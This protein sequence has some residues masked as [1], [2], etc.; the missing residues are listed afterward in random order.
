MNQ[1]WIDP[2]C[3]AGLVLFTLYLLV[4]NRGYYISDTQVPTYDEAWYL[5][6][7]LDLY[8]RLTQG[9]WSQFWEAYRGAFGAKAPLIAV[10]PLPFYLL[11]GAARESAMLVNSLLVALSNLCLFWMVRRWFSP[12]AALAAVVFYQ[13]MPLAYGLSRAFMAEYG[14]AALVLAWMCL[15]AASQR[16]ERTGVNLALGV[17]LGLGLLMKVLFPAFIAGPLAVMLWKRR[18]GLLQPLVAIAVPA[19]LLAGPWYA[20][21]LSALLP[22]AW[23]SAFGE[24]AGDYTAGGLAPWLLLL[25]NQGMSFQ[26]AAALAVL[27]AAALALN[28]RRISLGDERALALAAWLLLP[29]AALVAGRNQLLRF[30][31]PLLPVPAILLAVAVFHLGRWWIPQA[32]LAL[33]LAAFPQRQFAALSY[34]LHGPAPHAA[35]L[36][37]FDLFSPDLGWAHPPVWEDPA[38]HGRLL[39]TLRRLALDAARPQYVIV[40]V[41]HVY[42]NAN[43]LNYLNAYRQYPLRFTS[44][45]YAETSADAAV[46][47]IYRFDARFLI[48]EE[49][50]RA[51]PEFLNR[52]NHQIRARLDRSEL[53][54]VL[55]TT[56]PL[57][58]PA[59]ALVYERAAPWQKLAAAAPAPAHPVAA[60]FPGGLRLLGYDWRRRD[61]WLWEM[62][63]YWTLPERAPEDARVRIELVRAGKVIAES[64]YSIAG[65]RYPLPEW[66]PGEIIRETR[67][68]YLGTEEATE[69]RF[70]LIPPGL[71]AAA[72]PPVTLPLTAAPAR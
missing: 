65:G 9:G 41:E 13:T 47:R 39:E 45:G 16:L 37:P 72:V 34:P 69:A 10:L 14:L 60:D 17:V 33:A 35:R 23:H 53:P 15:L 32:A 52:V 56:V 6:T 18:R 55:R 26:Y 67:T 36:G 11:L 50:L 68:F 2:L 21:N 20:R 51:L 12:S 38:E 43:L 28:W 64:E 54:F 71:E 70:R 3:R 7:S 49:G 66:S 5:E 63:C 59:K 58:A 1:R 57:A 42:L 46:E 25:V 40:G 44:L 29:L 31:L 61:R 48:L 4:V 19:A 27:G 30:A 8:H 62:T 24:V 22:F